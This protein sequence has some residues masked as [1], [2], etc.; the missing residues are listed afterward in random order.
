M[1][2]YKCN[3][4]IFLR[5]KLVERRLETQKKQVSTSWP[6]CSF[7]AL[8]SEF[9]APNIFLVYFR[10]ADPYQ[11]L[12]KCQAQIY[13]DWCYVRYSDKEGILLSVQKLRKNHQILFCRN[14]VCNFHGLNKLWREE[15]GNLRCNFR[16]LCRI[17]W[18]FKSFKT[19]SLSKRQKSFPTGENAGTQL[20]FDLN[21]TAKEIFVIYLPIRCNILKGVD[22]NEPKTADGMYL[23]IQ[24]GEHLQAMILHFSCLS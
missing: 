1:D 23:P 17:L 18:V 15:Y 24:Y 22:R 21:G 10:P 12:N 13:F 6:H 7:S 14:A 11:G 8:I 19:F 2:H 9:H 3:I 4:S 5:S 20:N 16:A